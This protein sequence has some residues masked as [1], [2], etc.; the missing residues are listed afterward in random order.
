MITDYIMFLTI[1][2]NMVCYGV[3][4]IIP[5]GTF[6]FSALCNAQVSAQWKPQLCSLADL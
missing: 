5:S 3:T 2:N 1:E 4:F 6:A